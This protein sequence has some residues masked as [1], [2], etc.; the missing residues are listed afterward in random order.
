[1]FFLAEGGFGFLSDGFG[2]G[3]EEE[4]GVELER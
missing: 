2:E 4:P 1:L 3:V